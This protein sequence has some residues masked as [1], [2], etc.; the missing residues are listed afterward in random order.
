MAP[1]SKYKKI[2]KL[3]IFSGF[4]LYIIYLKGRFSEV[5]MARG[6]AQRLVLHV[7]FS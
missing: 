5:A 2:Y 7:N 4:Y 1:I 3:R 6:G